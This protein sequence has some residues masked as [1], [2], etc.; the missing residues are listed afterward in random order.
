MAVSITFTAATRDELENQIKAW[1]VR[2]PPVPQVL[3]IDAQLGP[4]KAPTAGAALTVNHAAQPAEKP[5]TL[6]ELRR[7]IVQWIGDDAERRATVMALL[8]KNFQTESIVSLKEDQRAAFAQLLQE[9]T[10]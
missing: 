7:G 2:E 4:I 6:E 9:H 3:H 5:M 8:K 10:T 1:A